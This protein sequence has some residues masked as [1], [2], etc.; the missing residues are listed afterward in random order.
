M[1]HAIPQ[2]GAPH[3]PPGEACGLQWAAQQDRLLKPQQ[4]LL[5]CLSCLMPN[6]SGAAIC[7]PAQREPVHACTWSTT[8]QPW[9]ALAALLTLWA[10]PAAAHLRVIVVL[11]SYRVACQCEVVKAATPCQVGAGAQ[12][13]HAVA[14]QVQD[15]KHVQVCRSD[16]AMPRLE[17]TA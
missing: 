2:T 8:V 11:L 17:L 9:T 13:L 16:T 5:T 10:T 1:H 3:A 12:V 7:S 15:L 6:P 4:C 14:L